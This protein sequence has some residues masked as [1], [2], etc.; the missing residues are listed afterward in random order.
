VTVVAAGIDE[1]IRTRE[2]VNTFFHFFEKNFRT[3]KFPST[4]SLCPGKKDRPQ[5]LFL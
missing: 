4:R 5:T 2:K 1:D 3:S